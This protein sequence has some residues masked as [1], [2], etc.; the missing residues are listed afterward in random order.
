MEFAP[1]SKPA[2]ANPEA[3]VLTRNA[4]RSER[5]GGEFCDIAKPFDTKI[6]QLQ[7]LWR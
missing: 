7:Q 4:V 6:V 1:S 2:P 3:S 5:S